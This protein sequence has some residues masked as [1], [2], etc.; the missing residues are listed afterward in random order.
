VSDVAKLRE[1]METKRFLRSI[2]KA[3]QRYSGPAAGSTATVEARPR[4][5]KKLAAE[6]KS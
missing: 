3:R 2:A 4:R 1:K 5:R 6:P